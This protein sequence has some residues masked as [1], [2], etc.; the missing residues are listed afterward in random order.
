MA[1]R[2]TSSREREEADRRAKVQGT[3]AGASIGPAVVEPVHTGEVISGTW[4]PYGR[5]GITEP[6]DGFLPR[7]TS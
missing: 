1:R 5:V 2:T 4:T 3:P 6:K 7:R